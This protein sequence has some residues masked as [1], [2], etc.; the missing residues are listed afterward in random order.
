LKLNYLNPINQINDKRQR[1]M[2]FEDKLNYAIKNKLNY[3]KHELAILS[4][5]LN[6]LSPL[7]KL[8]QGY[9]YAENS[10]GNSVN[11]INNVALNENIKIQVSDGV[12]VA[13]V[14]EKTS[15]DR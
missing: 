4:E 11:T 5:R 13:K 6:G 10:N 3:K 12:I 7:S 15:I 1:T 2:D 14:I 8:S 9:A